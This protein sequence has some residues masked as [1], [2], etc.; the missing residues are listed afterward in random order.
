MEIEDGTGKL[1]KNKK[2]KKYTKDFKKDM[3]FDLQYYEREKEANNDLKIYKNIQYLSDK[4][5]MDF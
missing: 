4:E 3:I 1:K 2:S 5:K